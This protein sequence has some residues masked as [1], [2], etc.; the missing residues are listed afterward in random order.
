MKKK[1]LL[2]DIDCVVVENFWVPILNKFFGSSYTHDNMPSFF[3]QDTMNAEEKEKFFDYFFKQKFYE[4]IPLIQGVTEVLPKLN[5]KY[6]L[7]FCTD[8]LI[9]DYEW[10]SEKVLFDR[11]QFLKKNFP[12]IYP[13]QYIILRN[14]H[15]LQADILIDDGPHNFGSGIK[16]RLLFTANPNKNLTAEELAKNKLIRV[17][18]WKEIEK[19]L[20]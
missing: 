3:M 7:Y 5:E 16:Q 1:T 8:Y 12:Y 10:E 2:I 15:L 13:H 20:I 14:K 9:R 18:S 6:D 4:D 17:N 11:L 19:L